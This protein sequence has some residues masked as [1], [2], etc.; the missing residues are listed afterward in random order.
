LTSVENVADAIILAIY[1]PQNAMNEIY[2]IT[3]GEPVNLWDNINDVLT[4]LG[5]QLNTKKIPTFVAK[6]LAQILELKSKLTDYKEPA[7]TNYSIGTLTQ[8]FTLDISKAKKLLNYIP[9]ISTQQSMNEFVN[10]Y[11]NNERT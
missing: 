8:S 1:A 11:K 9:R 3:N 5:K 6:S 10:W 7:L 4:A 2:N